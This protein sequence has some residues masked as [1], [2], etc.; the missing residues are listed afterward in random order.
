[1]TI[2]E[3]ETLSGMTR[4]N[5]R[6]YEAE[7]L[8]TPMRN[9]NG[10]RDYSVSDLDTLRRIKLLRALHI[11]LEEIREVQSGKRE[12]TEV[13]DCQI[14]ELERQRA[15]LDRSQRVCREMREDNVRFETLDAEKYL[16]SAGKEAVASSPEIFSDVEPK[17]CSPWRR[18]FAR[19]L[20]WSLYRTAW[21][22]LQ[23]GVFR[24][25]LLNRGA[26]W[27]LIDIL[28]TML[29]M[30]ALEPLFLRFFHTTPGKW[31]FGLSVRDNNGEY[32]SYSEGSA[33]VKSV[34]FH[35]MGLQIPVYSLVRL[36]KSYKACTDAE[37]LPWEYDSTLA[38]RDEKAWRGFAYVGTH[39]L[40][41]FCLLLVLLNAGMPGHRGDI[42][43]AQFCENY[44]A[45]A[46]YHGIYGQWS[47]DETGNW[48]ERTTPG[49]VYIN[50]GGEGEL[51]AF[52]FTE[53]DGV[54]TGVTLE[55]SLR[56]YDGWV[57]SYQSL[58]ELSVLSFVL[59][60][61]DAPLFHWDADKVTK[62]IEEHPFEDFSFEVY[63]VAVSCEF[64]YS[65]YIPG[66]MLFPEENE[67][68]SFSFRFSME[69][70]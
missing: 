17:V 33:R 50:I 21:L 35:G 51:P 29:L 15:D 16:N 66:P 31:I 23:A 8:L 36:W 40:L 4:A 64:D 18:Y 24:I 10:Y 28:V 1:M 22:M 30:L 5:I 43:T 56:D 13:L 68:N 65:G 48:V 62:H 12:L 70:A 14:A 53:E 34:L 3:M 63:G 52:S 26:F 55:Q 47:L 49:T 59:A 44:N 32:L 25:N 11:P 57:S 9:E 67:E 6:F 61:E 42:T 46:R 39:L 37:T 20:D 27:E 19:T 69:R 60:Q 54:L 2:K 45:C 41:F 58:M 38:L 7:G